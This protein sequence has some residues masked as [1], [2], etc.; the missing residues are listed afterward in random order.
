MQVIIVGSPRSGTSFL[1]GL[2]VRMGFDPGP[3]DSL[4]NADELNPYG[5]YENK[6]LMKIDH[7]LLRKFNGSVMNPPKLPEN[8]IELCGKEKLEINQIVEKEG[9]EVYKGNMLVV[10]A[11]LYDD[12]F[13]NAKWIFISRNSE[14]VA[15]SMLRA[16]KSDEHNS[17]YY[18]EVINKWSKSWE[19]AAVSKH[20]LN[21]KY[22]DFFYNPKKTIKELTFYLD[23]SLSQEELNI[24]ISFFKPNVEVTANEDS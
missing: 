13:P 11:D 22:E 20:C 8:W 16:D 24:C 3:L 4:R 6:H 19:G 14:E 9:V 12:L 21:I 17:N 18:A 1:T 5:Y 15:R 2:I 23:K 7:D 10:L